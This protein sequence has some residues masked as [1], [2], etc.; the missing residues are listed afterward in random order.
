MDNPTQEPNRHPRRK[1]Y[2]LRLRE[3]LISLRIQYLRRG[4]PTEEDHRALA[5]IHGQVMA[6]LATL[7]ARRGHGNAG[8]GTG[9]NGLG[10]SA[11]EVVPYDPSWPLRFEAEASEI[12][13]ALGAPILAVH[14]IG[15]TSIPG[16]PSKPIVDMAIAAEPSTF[17]SMLPAYVA[18]LGRLGYEY[19]GDW[20]HHGGHYFA[21]NAGRQRVCGVQLHPAD[22]AD[23]ADVLRFRD[24]ARADPTLFRD[25]AALKVALAEAFKSDRGL[26]LWHKG[27]WLNDRLLADRE[28]STWGRL[29][30]RAQYPTLIQLG[31]RGAFSRLRPA[32]AGKG[33]HPMAIRGARPAPS[34]A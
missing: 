2:R 4:H 28:P 24:A 27:H 26:Y 11:V 20:G 17:T 9:A 31:L 34:H 12:G 19:C 8:L 6:T 23:L 15:S 33:L 32:F 25:Y 13:Q 10:E 7:G 18:G 3:D 22:S 1:A 14:H 5:Q 30:V 16:M 29:F 21:K